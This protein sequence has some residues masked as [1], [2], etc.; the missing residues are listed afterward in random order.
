MSGYGQAIGYANTSKGIGIKPARKI[1]K[2]KVK[3]TFRQRIRN[4]LN[5]DDYDEDI[6]QVVEADKLSSE[7][8]RMQI[9]KASGGY[10]VETRLYDSHKDRHFNSIHII[11]DEQDLGD[12]LGS[13]VMME[14]LKR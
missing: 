2:Q 6:P 8:M 1:R 10:V 11:T 9:Y 14:A 7:G 12:A 4:W 5:K 13:I 3:L